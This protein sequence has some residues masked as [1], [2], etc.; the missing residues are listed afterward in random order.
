MIEFSILLPTRNRLEYLKLAVESVLRQDVQ[1]WQLVVSDNDSEQDIAG[2]VASLDD[3]RIV[4]GRTERL[5]AVTEN[6]PDL[7][8]NANFLAL[9]SQ[10]EGTENRIAVARRD[11]ILAVQQ[12][13]TEL[14]TIP[15]R[16]Y[17]SMF[18]G[19]KQVMQNFAADEAS[20]A[21]PKVQF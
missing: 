4:Y 14:T 17:R 9:Q 11:Y 8:S 16:W 1:D 10:L 15:G 3:R 19:D 2:Y 12:Y 13:N 20:Q 6:Y 7:K 18:Y 21:A 5:L